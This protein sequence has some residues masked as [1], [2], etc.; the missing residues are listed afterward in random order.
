LAPTP[1]VRGK[2]APA[3]QAPLPTA[4]PTNERE[5][6]ARGLSAAQAAQRY[7]TFGPNVVAAGRHRPVVLQLIL[8]FRDPLVLLL[9]FSA[10][11]AGVTGDHRSS[12]VIVVVVLLSVTLDFVQEHR[13]GRAAERLRQS[14]QVH[15]SV[16][17]DGSASEIPAAEVV[18]DDVV[19]L[20]AGDLVPADGRLLEARDLFVNQALLTGE[21]YPIEKHAGEGPPAAAGAATPDGAAPRPD[22]ADAVLMGTSVVSG[23]GRAV[24]VRTGARTALG[25]IGASLQ[26]EPPPSSFEQGARAFGVLI[27]KLALLLVLFV[28][29]VQ[30][31]RGRPWLQ[32]FL[33]AVALA[34]GLTP[35]LLP[36]VVS[37]TLSRGAMRMSRKKVLV[38]RLAA[39]HDLG[40]MDVLCTDKTGTLTEARIRLQQHLDPAG[41]DSQRVLELAFV[42]SH[43]GTGIKSPLDQAILSH[44]SE[45]DAGAAGRDRRAAAPAAGREGGA[46]GDPAPV[47]ALRG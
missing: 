29:L 13:A 32:S 44:A 17:R 1:G 45:V 18:P 46:G 28:I 26:R 24:I 4:P 40:S 41:R 21:P 15:A 30:A 31:W 2:L 11:V 16:L 36:M 33:F 43:F 25:E 27:L 10:V 42:N 5:G 47:G 9:L 39:I 3:V 7:A 8:R 20:S 38:K 22:E 37:V 34:V 19:L 6:A 35:E 23:S 14:A 12:A